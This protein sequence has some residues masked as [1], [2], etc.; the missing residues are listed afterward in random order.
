MFC[1]D[2]QM[3]S[4]RAVQ[5]RV[6]VMWAKS[7]T[8]K[9]SGELCSLSV[10]SQTPLPWRPLRRPTHE[11]YPAVREAIDDERLMDEA[12]VDHAGAKD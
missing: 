4:L 8:G 3:R 10:P 2:R 11:D 1:T 5:P 6:Q 9:R 7:H 12:N